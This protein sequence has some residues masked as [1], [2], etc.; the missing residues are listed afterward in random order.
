M[1]RKCIIA[2][3]GNE[4]TEACGIHQLCSSLKMWDEHAKEDK[5]GILL[6]DAC[7][8]FNKALEETG[9]SWVQGLSIQQGGGHT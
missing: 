9:S 4:V 7:N 1:I 8:A 5:W 2:V 6:V 3:C